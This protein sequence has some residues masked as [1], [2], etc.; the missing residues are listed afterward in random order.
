MIYV[1]LTTVPDRLQFEYS[2]RRCLTA[3][4]TQDTNAPYVILLSIPTKYKNYEAVEIPEWVLQLT[5]EFDNK[6]QI[7]RDDIDYG[8]ITNLVYPLKNVSMQPDDIII[9]VDDD[10]EYHPEMISHHLKKLQQYPNNHAIC[11]RGN[12]PMELRTWIEDEKTIGILRHSCV[13]FPTQHD[14]YLKFPDHWHSVSYRRKFFKDDF[15]DPEFLS[16]TWNNDHLMAYYAWLHDFYFLCATWEKETNYRP[17]N[18][19]GRGSSSFPILE[20]LPFDGNSGCNL[21]RQ[22][23]GS[24]ITTNE[25]FKEVFTDKPP[26]EWNF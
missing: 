16:M 24:D 12:Q 23:L 6:L 4:L 14:I 1:A 25:K 19:Y 21:W 22:Q 18:D 11:Y 15:F 17:V 26:M 5:S 13:L 8:P 9:V 20:S 7:I 10:H 2:F 3:L